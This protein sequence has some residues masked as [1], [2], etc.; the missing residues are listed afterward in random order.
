MKEDFFLEEGIFPPSS[1]VYS[2]EKSV[3]IRRSARVH[4]TQKTERACEAEPEG[5]G[6]HG[7]R[8][9]ERDRGRG[10]GGGRGWCAS[11][12]HRRRVVLPGMRSG[13]ITEMC[14]APPHAESTRRGRTMYQKEG[15]TTPSTLLPAYFIL[16]SCGTGQTP[17]CGAC[18][19]GE[20]MSGASRQGV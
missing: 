4:R 2:I 3:T 15:Y 7:A 8:S 6:I 10:T 5:R 18:G 1:N 12:G 14:V 13:T 19:G 11:A 9:Y 16:A 17:D 20:L